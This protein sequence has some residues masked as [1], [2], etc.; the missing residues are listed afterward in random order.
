MFYWPDWTL[1]TQSS[2]EDK[3]MDKQTNKQTK[4]NVYG[5]TLQNKGKEI[6][7]KDPK[8]NYISG[9]KN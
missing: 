5:E 2:H 1:G 8:G 7:A 9:K 4:T 3:L 6:S